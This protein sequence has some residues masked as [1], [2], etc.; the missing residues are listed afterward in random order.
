MGIGG[1]DM[2]D[3]VGTME[4]DLGYQGFDVPKRHFLAL[5]VT[6]LHRVYMKVEYLF[7]EDDCSSVLAPKLNNDPSWRQKF[8]KRRI[9]N[10][11]SKPPAT[12]ST[13][14]LG[15]EQQ[16]VFMN[17]LQ[18]FTKTQQSVSSNPKLAKVCAISPTQDLRVRLLVHH[19]VVR[20]NIKCINY[21]I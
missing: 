10:R 1:V 6:Y 8:T 3:D 11:H 9:D 5:L 7:I 18:R 21:L 14:Q 12:G 20:C 17:A 16:M 4:S 13:L 15:N 19:D 2:V